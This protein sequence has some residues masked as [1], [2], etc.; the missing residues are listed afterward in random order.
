MCCIPCCWGCDGRIGNREPGD[1]TAIH[2]QAPRPTTFNT[3]APAIISRLPS[4]V[5]TKSSRSTIRSSSPFQ[6]DSVIPKTARGTI[7]QA[8]AQLAY[9]L[10]QASTAAQAYASSTLR[11]LF[12]EPATELTILSAVPLLD[13]LLFDSQLFSRLTVKFSD[14]PLNKHK[15][16]RGICLPRSIGAAG[17]T[18][19][20]ISLNRA[21]LELESRE[22]IWGTLVHEMLHAWLDLT[23]DWRGLLGSHH[24]KA[25]EQ[26][27]ELLVKKLGFC[28]LEAR[29]VC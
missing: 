22:E 24:G 28:D 25:F 3:K 8:H 9:N 13:T 14:L 1:N 5:E 7:S 20:K 29:H 6:Y 10:S 21:V 16:L 17:V 18:S 27:C 19:A 11:V 26:S 12:A 4:R 15:I 23:A 2:A